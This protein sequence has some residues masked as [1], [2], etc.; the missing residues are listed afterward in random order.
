MCHADITPTVFHVGMNGNGI[1]PKLGATHI[2]RSFDRVRDWAK[3]REVRQFRWKL[4]EGDALLD[5]YNTDPEG[6]FEAGGT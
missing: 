3:S 2:C 6:F 4:Q 5:L 1:F